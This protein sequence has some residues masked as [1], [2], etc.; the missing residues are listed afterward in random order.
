MNLISHTFSIPVMGTGYTIDTPVKVAHL[1]ISSVVSLVDDVLI[2]KMREFYSKKF[3]IP[4]QKI[5]SKVEDFR[6]K[7]ISAYLNIVDK[8]VNEKYEE[9]ISNFSKKGSEL[10]KYFSLLPNSNQIW[11]KFTHLLENSSF[12]EVQSWLRSNLT[13]GKI[14]VNIMT[15]VDGSNV[16]AN[17]DLLP[18]EYNNAHAALRGFAN[19]KLCSSLVLSAGMNPKLYSYLEKF[20]D[21]YPDENG[22][23]QKKIILKV[24]DFRSA[25][26]QS[27]FL[28]KKGIW[29]SEFRVESGLNCG[30]HAFATQGHLLGPILSEFKEKRNE[31]LSVMFS[32]YQAG[33]KSKGMREVAQAPEMKLTAQGGVGTSEEHQFLLDEFKLDSVGWGSPFLLVPEACKI[34]SETLDLLKNAN[35]QD[36]FLSN[37][38]PLG[39]QF[40]NIRE[41]SQQK[42]SK[43]HFNAG[44]AGFPCT[45]KLLAFN[46]EFTEK[47]I[48]TASRQYLKMK[49]EA[50]DRSLRNET[51][52]QELKKKLIEK[53]CL[54]EGLANSTYLGNE[55]DSDSKSTGVSICPGPNLAYFKQSFSL[56]YM[57]SHIYGKINLLKDV[58]R[59]NLFIKELGMY[60]DYLEAK[61]KEVSKKKEDKKQ[62]N[63]YRQFRKNLQEG[64]EYYQQLFT[65]CECRFKEIKENVFC[66]LKHFN[67]RLEKI[68]F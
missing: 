21:F 36:F 25:M 5:S 61:L 57:T 55:I 10:E 13:K 9:M 41:S 35:E 64:I 29:V 3:D 62:V 24:S 39:V 19:S 37:A 17:G 48:C 65:N 16:S 59:P 66:E 52:K 54:C 4:Y 50:I 6:A 47:P 11:Q 32:T 53:E 27:R 67:A 46:T 63:Y 31:L 43:K 20:S 30:G 1:G 51:Q 49:F 22:E 34:D 56:K 44:K 8:L 68:N 58:K 15:K 7:R 18:S 38:S 60:V 12:K 26:I 28:A 42:F 23:L 40:N 33:L 2:E 45:K 14:D